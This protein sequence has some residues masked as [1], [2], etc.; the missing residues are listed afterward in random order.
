MEVNYD[1]K[2]FFKKGGFSLLNGHID[3]IRG[4]RA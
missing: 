1:K 4:G 3:G 2:N